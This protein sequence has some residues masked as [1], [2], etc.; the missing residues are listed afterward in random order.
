MG[1]RG[2][3]FTEVILVVVVLGILVALYTSS[4]GDL[5]NVSIDA[6]SRKVQSDL[7]YAHQRAIITG[8]NHGAV[9]SAGGGYHVY[10]IT[11]GNYAP[12]P[13][14][15]EDLV[16]DIEDFEGVYID[17]DYQV[18]FNPQGEPVMGGDSRVRLASSS[19]A[20]RDVYVVEKTGVVVVDLIEYG[21]GCACTMCQERDE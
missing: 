12:D 11:E 7:R 1:N 15:K 20:I 21:T 5:S 3:T 16:V 9:F 14:T 2:F 4:T 8:N 18:E 17:N 10:Q 6:A 19:G 13:V